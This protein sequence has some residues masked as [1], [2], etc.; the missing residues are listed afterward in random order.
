MPPI[1]GHPVSELIV[2][3]T[4]GRATGTASDHGE[5][6]WT[7]RPGVVGFALGQGQGPW[8]SVCWQL[9]YHGARRPWIGWIVVVGYHARRLLA[10]ASS[11]LRV[12]VIGS[13][14]GR[15]ASLAEAGSVPAP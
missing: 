12:R 5:S 15:M 8:F 3:P 6:L 10:D 13:V 2:C 11:Q 4:V 9:T 14:L 7:A 1:R